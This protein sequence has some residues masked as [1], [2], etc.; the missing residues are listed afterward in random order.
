MATAAFTLAAVVPVFNE[1]PAALAAGVGAVCWD[2][3]AQVL[4]ADASDNPAA[5]QAAHALAQNAPALSA[6]DC[7]RRGRARQMN[8]AAGRARA[9][10]LLFVHAD[11]RLP[12]DAAARVQDAV[13]RG[14]RWGRFDV[15]LDDRRAVFR[16]IAALINVR[17]AVSGIATGDQAIFVERGLFERL[18][19]FRDIPLM[20]DV[21]LSRRLKKTARPHRIRTPVL[22]SA[23]RWR[24]HGVARTVLL[25]W[26]LRFLYFAGVA[27]HRLAVWYGR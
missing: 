7:P 3:F 9:T 17:S 20:E 26:A 25:M 1:T 6:V 15:Q 8:Y 23:R 19:G 21:E 10:H 11:T 13:L 12:P 4:V 24:E 2:G 18:R 22:T 27:P 16:M 14:A 5:K